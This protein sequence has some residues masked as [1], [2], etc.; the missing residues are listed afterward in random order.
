MIHRPKISEENGFFL[1]PMSKDID[2]WGYL[3]NLKN[4]IQQLFTNEQVIPEI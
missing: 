4:E 2:D 3:I 1:S